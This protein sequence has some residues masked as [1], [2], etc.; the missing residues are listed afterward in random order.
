MTSH[1]PINNPFRRIV[2]AQDY[3]DQQEAEAIDI[4]Q[5]DNDYGDNYDYGNDYDANANDY[6]SP[7]PKASG[8]FTMSENFASNR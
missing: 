2:T 3:E 4:D 1:K 7:P 8:G 6:P 5:Q